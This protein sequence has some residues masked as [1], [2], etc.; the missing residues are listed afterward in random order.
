MGNSELGMLLGGG[1]AEKRYGL[2]DNCEIEV[3][4]PFCLVI[5]GASGDLT[6]KKIIPALYRMERD[7]CVPDDFVVLG[8][9]R[10]KMNNSAFR[11]LMRD[12]LK[13]AFPDDFDNAVWKKMSGRLFYTHV[14]YEEQDSFRRLR[15]HLSSLEKKHRTLGNR[16]LYL[17]VPPEVY[18]PIISNIGAAGLSEEGP[19]YT[20]I[21]IE[22]PFG[23][24]IGSARKLNAVLKSSFDERQIYR[25]DHYLAK[26]TVQNILM[27]RF[28]N[29]IFEPLWNR[30][31][32]DHVQITVAESIGVG[33]RAGY[34]EK[35]G[36]LRDMFQNHILQLLALTAL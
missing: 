8:V 30:R 18:E 2:I 20:H 3:P 26:E 23:R 15:R 4:G 24:D 29:S 22:K 28:A 19:G 11:E 31:Y 36:V 33:H 21:V 16:I 1:Q 7:R 34:Y 25:M 32:I 35:A 14:D 6:R 17:A 5:F 12:E 13:S 27:F 10:T 9:A